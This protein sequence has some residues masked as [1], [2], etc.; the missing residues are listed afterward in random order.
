MVEYGGKLLVPAQL[1]ALFAALR[2]VLKGQEERRGERLER[3]RGEDFDE[4]E[5]EALED[6]QEVEE[7]VRTRL[8]SHTVVVKSCT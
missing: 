3:R 5:Q 4:D 6:E 7:E 8:K 2:E 1:E